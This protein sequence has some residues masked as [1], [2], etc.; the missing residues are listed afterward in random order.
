MSFRDKRKGARLQVA[1]GY[2]TEHRCQLGWYTEPVYTEAFSKMKLAQDDR[3]FFVDFTDMLR[4]AQKLKCK[5]P[6]FEREQYQY[7]G[8]C[9]D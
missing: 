5:N 1:Y 4:D 2:A 7:H 6:A 9:F 3:F 8:D